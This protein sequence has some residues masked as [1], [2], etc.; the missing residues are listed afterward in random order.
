MKE[1]SKEKMKEFILKFNIKR[2]TEFISFIMGY[3]SCL[4]ANE[5]DTIIDLK[6]EG[7]ID[8]QIITR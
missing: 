7:F 6:M 1:L 4:T 8:D 5:W 3:K 2:R